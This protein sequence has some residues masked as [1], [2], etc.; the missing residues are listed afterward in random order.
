MRLIITRHGE[1][2]DNKDRILTGHLHGSLTDLGVE[3]ARKVANRL[4][5]ERIDHIFSS[6]LRRA[7]DTAEE[8]RKF[9]KEKPFELR[10]ELREL[11]MGGFQGKPAP[12]GLEEDRWIKG[13]FKEKGG[14]EYE[15][16]VI[17]AKGFLDEI[18]PKFKGKNV[19]VVAHNGI[20]LA[21]MVA[22]LNKPWEHIK[23]MGRIGNTSITVFEFDE[24]GNPNLEL[25]NCIKH[26]ED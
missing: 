10:D 12:K 6:P 23:E 18:N 21:L 3:Q 8:I 26:L 1:T 5:E 2:Q 14:E 11:N 16:L 13:F 15:E 4:K 9:H 17:R 19:L 20:N 22:L 25:F 24:N 7:K